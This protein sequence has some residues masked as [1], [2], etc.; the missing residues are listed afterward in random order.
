METI[1]SGF[2]VAYENTIPFGPLWELYLL[3]LAAYRNNVSVFESAP[4]DDID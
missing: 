4:D 3:V 2:L 1:E